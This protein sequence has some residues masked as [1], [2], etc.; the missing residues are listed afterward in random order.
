MLDDYNI[1]GSR[2]Q[3]ITS[4]THSKGEKMGLFGKKKGTTNGNGIASFGE[5]DFYKT[6]EYL[7][8][9]PEIDKESFLKDVGWT[10]M[11]IDENG[12]IVDGVDGL[13]P[14][15][16]KVL[17]RRFY[18]EGKL[19]VGSI[20]Q[21]ND[22]LY[23]R[24]MLDAPGAMVYSTDEYFYDH[25]DDLEEYTDL[26]WEIRDESNLIPSMQYL[27]DALESEI[28]RFYNV[29]LPEEIT[30][31]RDVRATTVFIRRKHLASK[32]LDLPYYPVLALPENEP[33]LFILPY[34]YW[35]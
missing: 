22:Q 25:P 15:F 7:A 31:G 4:A 32:K 29:K 20:I 11:T 28:E 30:E 2:R 3:Q 34:W 1:I 33:D 17:Q 21:A 19:A 27:V 10:E 5:L 6:R 18:K 35:R 23:R 8:S 26:L 9:G 12:D 24:G 16:S 13:A 14:L